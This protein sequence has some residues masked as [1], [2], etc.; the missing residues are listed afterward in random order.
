MRNTEI[1]VGLKNVFNKK[2]PFDAN[3]SPRFVS[4]FGD[5][6]DAVYYVSLKKRL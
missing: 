6:R 2:L 5:F 4:P 1:Q 3:Q